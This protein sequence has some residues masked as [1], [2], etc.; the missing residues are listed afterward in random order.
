[1]SRRSFCTSSINIL[2]NHTASNIVEIKPI[3]IQMIESIRTNIEAAVSL[4]L[5]DLSDPSVTFALTGLVL[6]SSLSLIRHLGLD[7]LPKFPITPSSS[8]L[9]FI[10]KIVLLT[11]HV[12]VSYVTSHGPASDPQPIDSQEVDVLIDD[13]NDYFAFN[14]YWVRLACLNDF[15]DKRKVRMFHLFNK[16]STRLYQPTEDKERSHRSMSILTRMEDLADIWGPVYTVPSTSG[17][18]RYYEVSKGVVCRVKAN[19]QSAVLGAAHCHYFSRRSFMRHN[20]SRLLHGDKNLYL[21]ENELLLIGAGLRENQGCHYKISDLTEQVSSDLTPLGTSEA[22]WRTESRSW[23]VGISKY[24][25]VTISGTQKLIPQTTLKQHV[26]GKWTSN[27]SRANPGILNQALGVEISHCT[28]NGRRTPLRELMITKPICS[29]LERQNPDWTKTPWGSDFAAALQ[30][31]DGEEIFYL[32]GKHASHRP[33]IANLVCGVLEFLDSTGWDE[34]N[35]FHSAIVFDNKES[36]LKIPAALNDWLAALK[37][38]HLTAAYVIT[39][40]VCLD[41][42]VPDHSTSTC[43]SVQAYTV[44]QTQLAMEK[45]SIPKRTDSFLLPTFGRPLQQV[46][47]GTSSIPLFAPITPTMFRYGR[48]YSC[49]EHLDRTGP[50]TTWNMVYLRASKQSCHGKRE[51]EN[52]ST[53][54]SSRFMHLHR[55]RGRRLHPDRPTAH[56]RGIDD[57]P[58][59]PQN[60]NT[61]LV[62]SVHPGNES[63]APAIAPLWSGRSIVRQARD[64]GLIASDV[65]GQENYDFIPYWGGGPSAADVSRL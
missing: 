43:Q 33:E 16:F 42:E 61:S 5:K 1:M 60:Q 24:I 37:D 8:M 28:G 23:A 36:A 41:C 18:V 58:E 13:G 39:N 26:L 25:G 29:V 19:E 11:D 56:E 10:R 6:P 57:V 20:T 32:W 54:Y 4:I 46:D 7:D 22:A 47:C 44:L 17:L 40:E 35:N 12:I 15:L 64:E 45:R 52:A 65:L 63:E 21:S 9:T 30:S 3:P 14:C 38:T 34:T 62:N 50:A 27:P 49:L 55:R 51:C 59:N 53:G 2:V 48:Q 31:D